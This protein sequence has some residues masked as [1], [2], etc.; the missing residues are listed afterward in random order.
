MYLS[1]TARTRK[2]AIST[3]DIE[4]HSSESSP[5]V[6]LAQDWSRTKLV[7]RRSLR[8][9]SCPHVHRASTSACERV[10]ITEAGTNWVSTANVVPSGQ[11]FIRAAIASTPCSKA[12][13]PPCP[14]AFPTG[15]DWSL[16][17]SRCL[18]LVGRP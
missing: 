8:D 1:G 7:D 15:S 4:H 10:F 13:R 16:Q 18:T 14:L 12:E 17:P 9:Q 3:A 2:N 5:A 6:S 11:A